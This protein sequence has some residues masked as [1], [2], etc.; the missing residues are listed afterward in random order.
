MLR[1]RGLGVQG[2]VCGQ[3]GGSGSGNVLTCTTLDELAR[4]NVGFTSLDAF[5]SPNIGLTT[6]DAF[7]SPNLGFDT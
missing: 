1:A 3:G 4:T 5:R 2:F 7:G 6:L